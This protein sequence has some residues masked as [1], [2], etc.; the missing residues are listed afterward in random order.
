VCY[1]RRLD[2][3]GRPSIGPERRVPGETEAC[4]SSFSNE[5]VVLTLALAFSCKSYRKP[6]R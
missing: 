4:L 6:T 3:I 2:G 5:D 1:S